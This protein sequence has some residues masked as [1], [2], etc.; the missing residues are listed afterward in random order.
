MELVSAST[1]QVEAGN[2]FAP[3]SRA[4]TGV[5]S[6]VTI[7]P[8]VEGDAV[9]GDAVGAGVRPTQGSF[10]HTGTWLY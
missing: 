3:P 2:E 6:A 1:M 9:V 8:G 4:C 7:E 10:V 5:A